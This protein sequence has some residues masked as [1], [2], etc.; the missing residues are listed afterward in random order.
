MRVCLS[1]HVVGGMFS[2]QFYLICVLFAQ[3]AT[4]IRMPH[5]RHITECPAS[6]SAKALPLSQ[7]QQRRRWWSETSQM[8]TVINTTGPGWYKYTPNKISTDIYRKSASMFWMIQLILLTTIS[9][10]QF[11]LNGYLGDK[12][13]LTGMIWTLIIYDMI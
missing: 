10:T 13:T 3:V 9:I 1:G 11:I 6:A 5:E 7:L 4:S 12:C 2:K 8:Q